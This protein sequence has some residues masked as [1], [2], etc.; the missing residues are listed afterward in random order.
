MR[1]TLYGTA[2][3]AGEL[4]ERLLR[5]VRARGFLLIAMRLDSQVQQFRFE[6]DVQGER[7]VSM[8]ISQ[9]NKLV[10]VHEVVCADTASGGLKSA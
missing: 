4:P 6:L 1:H 5:I 7:P 9:L 10:G 8:L 2:H 3:K